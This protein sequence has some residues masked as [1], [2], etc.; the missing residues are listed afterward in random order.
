VVE[1]RGMRIAN[2]YDYTNALRLA[3]PGDT[4][5]VVVVRDGERLTLEA[6]LSGR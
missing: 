5:T 3:Q 6:K 4:V 2:I 1:F